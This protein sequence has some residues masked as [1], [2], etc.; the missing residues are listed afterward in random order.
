VIVEQEAVSKFMLF[1]RTVRLRLEVTEGERE[2]A[3]RDLSGESFES[4]QGSWT[5]ESDGARTRVFYVLAA[6]PRFDVPGF[7]LK[8][9]LTSNARETIAQLCAEAAFRAARVRCRHGPRTG[10]PHRPRPVPTPP[11]RPPAARPRRPHP[12]TP[13]IRRAEGRRRGPGDGAG[14]PAAS[15]GAA[16]Q[17]WVTM[18]RAILCPVD[19]SDASRGALRF[20]AAISQHFGTR[21][22]VI[23]VDDPLLTEAAA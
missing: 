11:R 18:R 10:R 3:F 13:G 20:A 5:I 15:A 8:S 16:G 2:L 19:F 23:T 7:V 14:R 17:E 12:L 22:V 21:L 4:Y 6:Q 9:V 1:S